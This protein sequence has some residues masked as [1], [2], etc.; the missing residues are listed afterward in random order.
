MGIRDH[1]DEYMLF[2]KSSLGRSDH[3]VAS[4]AADLSQFAD[5]FEA[6]PQGSPLDIRA[7]RAFARELSGFGLTKS[8]ISRKL[9]ALRGFIKFLLQ[10]GEISTDVSVGLKGPR[11]DA[12][13]PRAVAYDDVMKMLRD[14]VGKKNHLR[15]SLILEIL[16]GSGLRAGEVVGLNW[17]SVDEAERWFL[18]MGKGS[19]ERYVPFSEAAQRLVG[20]WRIFAQAHGRSTDANAP[21]FVGLHGERLLEREV[22]RVVTGAAKRVGLF[23][24]HP[25]SLRHSFA[26]HMLERGAPLRVVQELLGHESLAATQR[27][28]TVT[29]EQMKK[30]YLETH[31]RAAIE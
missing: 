21:L 28:L 5:F 9:S 15:D 29:A 11:A 12:P 20:E 30:S 17:G 10:R 1:I 22:H 25:H 7:L 2:I 6:Q 23:G 4:Y 26:T 13:L 18:V 19:K 31:P 3:T 24:V 14:G 8:S 16:Y 27:Y